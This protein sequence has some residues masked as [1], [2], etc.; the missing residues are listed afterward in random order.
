MV[1]Q[2]ASHCELEKDLFVI[3]GVV[4]HGVVHDFLVGLEHVLYG[5]VLVLRFG[6]LFVVGVRRVATIVIVHRYVQLRGREAGSLVK[7][8]LV[9]FIT[10]SN[11]WRR[12]AIRLLPDQLSEVEFVGVYVREPHFL[13]LI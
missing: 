8:E 13:L 6:F 5:N 7:A 12:G 2:A 9:F 11:L 3:D 10:V 1:G 4:E